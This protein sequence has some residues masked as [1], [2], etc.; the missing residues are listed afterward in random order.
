MRRYSTF[1]F[2]RRAAAVVS[3]HANDLAARR[4]LREASARDQDDDKEDEEEEEEDAERG[5]AASAWVDGLVG[6]RQRIRTLAA[7]P[8]SSS[9]SRSSSSSLSSSSHAYPGLF[10]YVAW[11]AVH[12]TLSIPNGY[13][14]S[15]EYAALV[16]DLDVDV[17]DTANHCITS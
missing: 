7:T 16:A 15:A 17:S 4:R 14:A 9:S 11:N 5:G 12:T 8:P 13:N 6:Q 2:A 3:A 10:L 1:A